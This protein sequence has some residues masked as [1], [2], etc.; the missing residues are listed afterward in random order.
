MM[1]FSENSRIKN[2]NKQQEPRNVIRMCFY[3]SPRCGDV[4]LL[5]IDSGYDLPQALNEAWFCQ[6]QIISAVMQHLKFWELLRGY[7]NV[8]ALRGGGQGVVVSC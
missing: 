8:R 7:I 5:W 6:L 4:G 2:K 1:V 3:F